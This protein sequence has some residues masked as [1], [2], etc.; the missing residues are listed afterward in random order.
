M[1]NSWYQSQGY[2]LSTVVQA[3]IFEN[4]AVVLQVR[5][6]VASHNTPVS[7]VFFQKQNATDPA[8]PYQPVPLNKG[9][10][11]PKTIQ[12][13]LGIKSGELM[14]L[15]A[16]RMA[17]L[18]ASPLYE[19]VHVLGGTADAEGA[20]VL[21]IGLCERKSVAFEPGVTKTLFDSHWAGEV[22]FEDKN[23]LG[24]NYAVGLDARRSMGVPKSS[25]KLRV[26][27]DRF[28]SGMQCLHVFAST[29]YSALYS[30]DTH[31]TSQ[32]FG[33]CNV[34]LFVHPLRRPLPAVVASTSCRIYARGFGHGTAC[35]NNKPSAC[36]LVVN[37][38][39]AWKA[40]LYRDTVAAGA[41][42][43]HGSS[44]DVH[45]SSG[46]TSHGISRDVGMLFKSL[47]GLNAKAEH[48]AV[49]AAHAAA[50]KSSVNGTSTSLQGGVTRN[51][52]S[53][54]TFWPIGRWSSAVDVSY[55][56]M[57]PAVG[58]SQELITTTTNYAH[59]IASNAY[60]DVVIHKCKMLSIDSDT[61]L[62]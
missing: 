18:S 46:L 8:S 44:G 52:F 6:P 3:G 15:N 39:G 54:Q 31:F 9:K 17:A 25:F 43:S 26:G 27:N 5:E 53:L 13:A 32:S 48:D 11:Q 62:S 20:A 37:R 45:A 51:G 23:V 41:V 56:E 12:R 42:G 33:A 22:T 34:Y 47:H 55:E 10:T 50:D 38:P 19:L 60:A 49:A 2:A 57:C 58:D 36:G 40:A 28:S 1:I 61:Q 16:Q 30:S 4:G 35:H 29:L 14:K 7:L 59:Y 24:R 21:Q